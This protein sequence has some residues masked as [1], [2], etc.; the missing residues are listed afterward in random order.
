MAVTN[1]VLLV[2]EWK[3]KNSRAFA[4]ITHLLNAPIHA[5]INTQNMTGNIRGILG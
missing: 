2:S 4:I 5:A 1:T 3:M